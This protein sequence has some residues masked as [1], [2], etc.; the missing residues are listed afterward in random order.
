MSAF[1]E[2]KTI[3]TIEELLQQ[4]DYVYDELA[5]IVNEWPEEYLNAKPEPEGWSM[6]KNVRHACSTNTLIAFWVRLPGLRLIMLGRPRANSTAIEEVRPTNRPKHFDYAVY[7]SKPEIKPG[8]RQDLV[9]ALKL[10]AIKMKKAIKSRPEEHFTRY[11]G[12][13]GGMSMFK[14]V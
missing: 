7:P 5:G 3:K 12:P 10:S 4:V 1:P 2:V 14:A 8:L 13:F 11:K 9:K 6:A